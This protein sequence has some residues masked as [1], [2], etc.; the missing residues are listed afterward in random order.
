MAFQHSS[1][2]E[3]KPLDFYPTPPEL[4][5]VILPQL[6][7]FKGWACLWEPCCGDGAIS[8]QLKL[9]GHK[10]WSTDIHDYGYGIGQQA[11]CDFLEQEKVPPGT[12]CIVTNPPYDRT[13]CPK[14]VRHALKLM[15]PVKGSVFMLLRHNWNTAGGRADL[16][17]WPYRGKHTMMWRPHWFERKPG[18][19]TPMHSYSWFEWDWS[20]PKDHEPREFHITRGK[21]S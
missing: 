9:D 5:K 16:F 4:T 19:A 11:K 6:E 18:D 13:L 7:K 20:L 21:D 17:E 3:K 2:R 15:E 12:R 10:V 14:I 8:D 1:T